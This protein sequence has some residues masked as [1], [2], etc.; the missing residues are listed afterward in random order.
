M[1]VGKSVM[2]SCGLLDGHEE[3]LMNGLAREYAKEAES[4]VCELDMR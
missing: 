1:R 3:A 2:G 4:G